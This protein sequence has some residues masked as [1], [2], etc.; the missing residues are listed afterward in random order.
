MC[1][2]D[3]IVKRSKNHGVN[4]GVKRDKGVLR[5]IFCI[6]YCFPNRLF[7]VVFVLQSTSFDIKEVDCKIQYE[8]L[9][10]HRKHAFAAIKTS[11]PKMFEIWCHVLEWVGETGWELN[12]VREMTNFSR[13]DIL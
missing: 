10:F 2:Y 1:E 5:A 8:I 9:N 7:Y 13:V 12:S 11:Y 4:V 3:T 6:L